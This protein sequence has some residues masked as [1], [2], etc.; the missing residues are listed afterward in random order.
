MNTPRPMK[1]TTPKQR[2]I[3]STMHLSNKACWDL[4]DF[5]GTCPSV[6]D[7]LKDKFW[8]IDGNHRNGFTI[9]TR[10]ANFAAKL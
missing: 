3:L 2:E 9:S 6:L 4:F 8:A 7:Q 10:G 5:P 1:L